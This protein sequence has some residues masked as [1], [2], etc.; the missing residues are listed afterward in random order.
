MGK[1]FIAERQH[2]PRYRIPRAGSTVRLRCLLA[3]VSAFERASDALDEFAIHT[4]QPRAASRPQSRRLVGGGARGR[5]PPPVCWPRRPRGGGV[6]NNGRGRAGS[7]P[8]A[9]RENGPAWLGNYTAALVI[10][11]SALPQSTS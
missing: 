7:P 2:A 9:R 10:H 5:P 8:P 3:L 4:D 1:T 11:A 6:E